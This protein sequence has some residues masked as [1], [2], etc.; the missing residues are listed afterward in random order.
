MK[1]VGQVG[2]IKPLVWCDAFPTFIKGQAS[3]EEYQSIF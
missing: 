1:T 3:Q 2:F